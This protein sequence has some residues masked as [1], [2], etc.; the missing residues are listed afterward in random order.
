MHTLASNP[1]SRTKTFRIGRGL[2]SGR[3]KT[4]GRGTKGQR[5]RTGG[6][7][8][9]GLKGMK[10]MLLSFPK[11]RG[12]TSLANKPH[13]VTLTQLNI[14][15]DDAQVTIE[16]LLEHELVRRGQTAKIVA[17]GLLTKRL[18]VSGMLLSVGAREAVEKAGGSIKYKE[19]KHKPVK[20]DKK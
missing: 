19:A 20:H 9:L 13:T 7:K 18:H 2:G 3:G 15:P 10:Q 4:S 11:Q 6:R 16:S 1:G 5:S 17:S 8:R 14:F 12:F